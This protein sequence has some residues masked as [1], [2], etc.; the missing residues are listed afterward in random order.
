MASLPLHRNGLAMAGVQEMVFRA[1]YC[2][3]AEAS[4]SAGHD[5]NRR[6]VIYVPIWV[7]PEIGVGPVRASS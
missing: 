5:A 4:V 2:A 1:F 6:Y 7:A 3:K